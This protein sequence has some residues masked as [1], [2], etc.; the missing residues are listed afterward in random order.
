MSS[1]NTKIDLFFEKI[2]FEDNE[3]KIIVVFKDDQHNKK[4]K[5]ISK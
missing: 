1:Y 2:N 4:L 5:N 3:R